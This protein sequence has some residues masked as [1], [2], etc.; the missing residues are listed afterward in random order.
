MHPG[1]TRFKQ[2]SLERLAA[3]LSSAEIIF[4]A[5]TQSP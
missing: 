5:L 4:L 1:V 3:S 2:K